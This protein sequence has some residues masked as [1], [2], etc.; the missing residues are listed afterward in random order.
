MASRYS[1]AASSVECW[2]VR[3]A[4]S[5]RSHRHSSSRSRKSTRSSARCAKCCA[6]SSATCARERG[7]RT[8][9]CARGGHVAPGWR[10]CAV[11]QARGWRLRLASTIPAMATITSAMPMNTTISGVFEPLMRAAA[12]VMVSKRHL[13]Y[14]STPAYLPTAR[15]RTEVARRSSATGFKKC[16]PVMSQLSRAPRRW[17]RSSCS[18]R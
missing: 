1:P 2:C 11:L 16:R 9:L 10:L 18:P 8:W 15:L 3:P 4:M 6:R 7:V 13:I 5:L 12:T 17:R 14:T